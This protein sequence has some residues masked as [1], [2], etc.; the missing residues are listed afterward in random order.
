MPSRNGTPSPFKSLPPN[1]L[2]MVTAFRVTFHLSCAGCDGGVATDQAASGQFQR[3]Q[4][5]GAALTYAGLERRLALELVQAVVH[6]CR[7]LSEV[8]GQTLA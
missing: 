5:H 6:S 4:E 3:R 8:I 2:H 1:G 7:M